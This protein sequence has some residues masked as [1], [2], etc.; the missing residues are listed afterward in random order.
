MLRLFLIEATRVD[1]R[2]R[3]AFS[4]PWALAHGGRERRTHE[5]RVAGGTARA[6][7]QLFE[8]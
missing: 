1:A 6:L 8:A 4:I 2:R 5:R 7:A 3:L